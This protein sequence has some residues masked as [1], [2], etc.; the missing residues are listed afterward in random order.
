LKRQSRLLLD[1]AHHAIHA[2][3]I[4]IREGEVEFAVGRA[5]YAMFYAV[6]ALLAENDLGSTKHSGVHALFGEY[7]AKPG[8]IDPKFHRFLLDGFDRRLQADYSFEAVIT[9]EEVI[10]MV[11][12]ARELL[13]HAEKL[14]PA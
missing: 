12:Q 1:K 3:E 6:S 9:T 14:L 10:A 7:F 13:A 2:A 8:R 11:D 4:L 5:Y